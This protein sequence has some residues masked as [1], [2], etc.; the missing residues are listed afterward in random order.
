HRLV[1]W[2]SDTVWCDA[3]LTPTESDTGGGLGEALRLYR[4]LA[5]E[6]CLTPFGAMRWLTLLRDGSGEV[7]QQQFPELEPGLQGGNQ[8]VF[9]QRMRAVA[10]GAQAVECGHA[11]G[12]RE[13]RIAAAACHGGFF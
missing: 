3:H 2:V 9:V 7:A 1:R 6:G 5:P 10:V 13:I 11:H 8:D 12:G 4:C